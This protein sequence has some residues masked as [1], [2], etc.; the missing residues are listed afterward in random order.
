MFDFD[1][2][3]EGGKQ[4]SVRLDGVYMH[5]RYYEAT[6]ELL[7]RYRN[8]A[9]LVITRAL[10]CAAPCTAMGIPAVLIAKDPKENMTRLL[11][12]VP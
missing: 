11:P 1:F 10:H 5:Q 2:P 7:E 12:L 9:R 8:E 6:S 3:K 4:Q